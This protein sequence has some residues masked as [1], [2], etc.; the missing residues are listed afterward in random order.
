MTKNEGFLSREEFVSLYDKCAKLLHSESLYMSD[1]DT[2]NMYK[3]YRENI[4]KWCVSIMNLLNP[5]IIEL[6][7]GKSMFYVT[8]ETPDLTG[9]QGNIFTQIE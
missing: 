1:K 3:Y 5:H 8:M 7:D 2:E 9:P 4:P 6:A